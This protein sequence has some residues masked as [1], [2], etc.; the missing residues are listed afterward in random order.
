M[1]RTFRTCS[2]RSGQILF[3][4]CSG[5][6]PGTSWEVP[7][8]SQEVPH[9]K[10]SQ[11]LLGLLHAALRARGLFLQWAKQTRSSHIYIYI[12]YIHIYI[13]YSLLF[14]FSLFRNMVRNTFQD[15]IPKH[16]P[17][18]AVHGPRESPRSTRSVQHAER[19]HAESKTN[20]RMF[21]C[22]KQQEI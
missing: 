7:R 2:G 12:Y 4:T 9:P 18:H 22:T 15:I 6:V 3:R 10:Q 13:Y 8:T 21:G 19:S 14:H 11:D 1:F 5:H 17:K 16:V 20:V